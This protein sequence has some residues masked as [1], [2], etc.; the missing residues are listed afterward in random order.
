MMNDIFSKYLNNISSLRDFSLTI[1]YLFLP[2]FCPYRDEKH[3]DKNIIE[4]LYEVYCFQKLN[5]PHNRYIYLDHIR[6]VGSK[7]VL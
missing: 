6:F 2:I 1:F 4:L 5:C 7:S 3:I